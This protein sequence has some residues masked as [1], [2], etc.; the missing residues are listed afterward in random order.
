MVAVGTVAVGTVDMVAVDM[1]DMAT[2]DRHLAT[3]T[4]RAEPETAAGM[5]SVTVEVMAVVTAVATVGSVSV[6]PIRIV[7]AGALRP[8]VLDSE[9]SARRT[10][11]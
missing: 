6:I 1:V 4:G 2:G 8:R 3:G 5:A 10:V 9:P 7:N 11:Q